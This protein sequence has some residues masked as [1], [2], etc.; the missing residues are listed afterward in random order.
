[1]NSAH[2]EDA[3]E[4]PDG[5]APAAHDA[6]RLYGARQHNLRGVDVAFPKGALTVVT[7]VSGS[8][9]S[10]LVFDTLY[11][12][13]QRRY[14]ESFS[15]YARQFLERMDRPDLDRVE[16]LLPAVAV[17]QHKTVR[18]S[19]ATLGSLTELTDH[20]K[21]LFHARAQLHC[22]S[23]DAVVTPD[24]PDP[25]ARR[26]SR[27]YPDHRA[28][29]TFPFHA[30]D[31]PADAAV[32]LDF[33]R[34]E[35]F[36]RA[37][38]PRPE[39][40]PPAQALRPV[41]LDE[42]LP[43]DASHARPG[44]STEATTEAT[45]EA[46]AGAGGL[47]LLDVVVDRLTLR[48]QAPHGRL[49]EALELA[50]RMG[51]DR[52]TVSLLP[53][54]R[55]DD[56]VARG[57]SAQVLR[58]PLTLAPMHCGRRLPERRPGLF[59]FESPLGACETCKGF[60][61]V[62][63]IDIDR[64]VPDHRKPLGRGA[65]RPWVTKGR[66]AGAERRALTRFCEAAGI[67]MDVPF[68]EL[69]PAHQ[70][71][72][73]EG[74]KA[75]ELGTPHPRWGGVR[76]WFRRVE[77]KSYKMHVRVFLARYRRYTRCDA[78]RGTRFQ[79]QSLWFRLGGLT[80]ASALGQTVDQ[81]LT[82]LGA[83]P[84]RPDADA[85]L[86]AI[87]AA[88]GQ[89]L[90]YLSRV[91]LGYLT[92][93]RQ[94]RTLSGGELQRAHLTTAMGSGLVQTL[95]VFDE[96]SVG[97]HPRDVG[98]L[99]TLLRDLTR[100]DGQGRG[101]DNT[102]VVVEHDPELLAAADHV[103]EL[104][105]GPGAAG[106]QVVYAGAPAGLARA[107]VP[108]GRALARRA[109]RSVGR[110]AAGRTA[111]PA[112]APAR[113]GA[114]RPGV[115]ILGA[116]AQNLDGVD[117]H[118]PAGALT[119]L[120]G[121]S[122]S[123]KST[124]LN[125]VLY[126]GALRARGLPTD[127]PG[128]CDAIEGLDALADVVWVDP[129][130]PVGSAR[131]NPAT[132]L[133][134]WD[135][136]RALFA[137]QDL[138]QRRGYTPATFSFNTGAGRCPACQGAGVERVEMQFLSDVLLTCQACG[139]TRFVPEVLDV[140]L[141][142]RLP[143]GAG[144]G[145]S[146]AD[147]LD[148]TVDEAMALFSASGGGDDASPGSRTPDL[149]GAA[150]ARPKR[151]RRSP[152]TRRLAPLQDVGLGYLRLG[153]PLA[154]LS[155]GEA[156]RLK[157]AHALAQAKARPTLFLLDEPTT[158]LHLADVDQLLAAL[159]AL[160]AR[161]HTVVAIEHHLDVI[162]AA[163]HPIELGPEGGPGGGHVVYAGTAQGLAALGADE[164]AATTHTARHL[165][166]WLSA[167]PGA[168]GGAGHLTGPTGPTA[169]TT[170]PPAALPTITVRG[171]RVHNLRDLSVTLPRTG[172]TVVAGVSGSGK[173]SLAFDLLFAEGQR[174]FLDCL[175]P[176]VRQYLS[177]RGRP[178]ADAV[179][180]VPPT[181][182]ID[183]RT[184]RGDARATVASATELEPFL[185]LAFAR[186]GAAPGAA[187]GH[188]DPGEL[189][190]LLAD[191]WAARRWPGVAAAELEVR[192]PAVRKRKGFH[193]AVFTAAAAAGVAWARVDGRLVDL[194]PLA[195][196]GPPPKLARGRHHDIDLLV[197]L[198]AVSD[199]RALR[200]LLDRAAGLGDGKVEVAPAGEAGD[201]LEPAALDVARA[202]EAGRR[203]SFDPRIFSPRT[204]LGAC[205]RCG[206]EGRV[207][208]GARRD[209]ASEDLT[210]PC[211]ACGGTRLGALG[212]SV[213]LAGR[214]LPQ[215]LALTP[216]QLMAFVDEALS[217]PGSSEVS[218]PLDARDRAVAGAPLGAVAER[219]RFLL[220]VGLGYLTLD[221]RVRT[222]SG[223]ELQRIRLASQLGAELSGVLYVLDEPTI[224]LHPTDV[225]V[226]LGTLDR[227][228]ARGN[229]VL[230]V[231]HDEATLRTADFLVDIGPG[232]GRNGGEVLVAA[233]LEEAL[234]DPRSVTARCLREPRAKVR[235]EARP[236]PALDALAGGS[237]AT[238]PATSPGAFL[239]MRGVRHHNLD[240]VDVAIPR[241]RLTVVTG[242]SGSGKSM[243]GTEVLRDVVRRG[244]QPWE[245]SQAHER[246]RWEEA[247]GLAGLARFV[248]VDDKP[249]GKNP[250]S[251]PAT[252]VKV[253]DAIRGLFARHPEAQV[254][255][256]GKA[257]FSFNVSADPAKRRG[258]GRC[259][260]CAGQGYRKLEMSFLPDALVPCEV[261]GGRR[262]DAETLRVRWAD[263][264]QMEGAQ[265]AQDGK[266]AGWS[267]HDVLEMTVSEALGV[268]ERVP[269][270][271]PALRLLEQVG[272]GYL[273]LGQPTPTLSGGEAQRLKLVAELL[274]VVK[275]VRGRADA[276]L[277][278]DEPSVGLH[279]A[280]VPKLLSVLHALVDAGATVVVIEH[281]PDVM[282][283]ADWL[284]DL[285]PGAGA[286]GGRVLYQGPFAGLVP[287]SRQPGHPA[288]VSRTAAYLATHP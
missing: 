173:S 232:A 226:L 120:C 175:S 118:V 49:A 275:G 259:E 203:P 8:G 89:R 277:V 100:G 79:P 276:V 191:G 94:A 163:D 12:E 72:V 16:G 242:V 185:R 78:C 95:F 114:P 151:A 248:H 68:G 154:T 215:V 195:D 121:V 32:A 71:A 25:T 112:A 105:P 116:R 5:G 273:A 56:D 37:L 39:D 126:R 67:A 189:A 51:E 3:S 109:G 104:G 42:L 201:A 127:P 233:P 73:L 205:P 149:F 101:G 106:G 246:P 214:T 47:G 148:L 1:M 170:T 161:G 213:T 136:I 252:Y 124:L 46:G 130:P 132:Y 131:A 144:A 103:I 279:M 283:E 286:E 272:L 110:S 125:Q 15:S 75:G 29:V 50:F 99:A 76:G 83:L 194:R 77:R 241:G 86:Q 115:T 220:D 244:G 31:S 157:I 138:A 152:V 14:V 18:S 129:T 177:Q 168:L 33:L 281:N 235:P 158:G 92:L 6:I 102:V 70:R 40:L 35:G 266:N 63:D 180:G 98:R 243:L 11:A 143:L 193:K 223:G 9:K 139:G 87:T 166:R 53:P 288:A 236:V 199:R 122:G 113:R 178:D 262:F 48:S 22:P 268:F 234:Q 227:I 156:Q 159:H 164:T 264:K 41:P 140:V 183:Q 145:L 36:T 258:G 119:V 285:G 117:A 69:P 202:S 96:P 21:L 171:A 162:A 165:A 93:D 38:P 61:R 184:T 210:R 141:N 23:C 62:V 20:L 7:G 4:S 260:A 240:G 206:G 284:L 218:A 209:D 269:K 221:R 287:A 58:L 192:V 134:A 187:R 238:S 198:A 30:G 17:E 65:I 155:G 204:E 179:E 257:R 66:K 80:I 19:R 261:C 237:S 270:V 278:L 282:R 81:A 108:T 45:T 167:G 255:G 55:A 2:D 107:D 228:Q 44:A 24:L 239:Q 60:G 54:R 169:P 196:G 82:W 225:Q 247:R 146:V 188:R 230:M 216:G 222:L 254:R 256:F 211:P 182:A 153:Q 147:V 64:V 137:R 135:P 111:K 34:R 28:V 231:E 207:E 212:R 186:A 88:L 97:L 274:S 123:G 27:D 208:M 84:P 57:P 249:I 280:D 250:R 271:A 229:G 267:I 219:A 59:A 128:A 200:E 176:Y 160:T 265:G 224:G 181:V 217:G 172:R 174:R 91:G 150:R 52:A 197:G 26:L 10:S 90:R 263:A 253:W 142:V 13:G 85:T 133:K 190:S 251:T 43:D 74:A 245:A